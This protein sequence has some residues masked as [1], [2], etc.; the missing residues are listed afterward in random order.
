[1]LPTL[2]H[3]LGHARVIW[4]DDESIVLQLLSELPV[5]QNLGSEKSVKSLG[6]LNIKDLFDPF[7]RQSHTSCRA[8]DPLS[9]STRI[10]LL[11]AP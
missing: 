5:E 9:L 1:M 4:I 8:L 6:K 10:G 7:R 3:F 11:S 2:R